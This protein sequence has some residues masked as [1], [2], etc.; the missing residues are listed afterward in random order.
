MSYKVVNVHVRGISPLICHNGQLVDP[1]NEFVAAIKKLT[2]K[3]KKRT[4]EDIAEIARFEFMGG[5]Y[6]GDDGGP[7]VPGECIESMLT[8]A[9]R[10]TKQGKDATAGILSDGN[11]P[12]IYDGPREPEK[13]WA[14]TGFRKVCAVRVGQ[15][16]VIRCRPMFR[17]W[18]LAFQV[19]YMPDVLNGESL[20]D[21][22]VTAGRLVGLGDWRP[23]HGR[24]ELVSFE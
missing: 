15:S 24:F 13:L 18:E 6:I 11:W 21:W 3:G 7:C 19:G 23:K 12:I 10:K 17:R 5:L 1:L 14:N 20:K 8:Q 16:K 22:L 2:A 9:A 4:D